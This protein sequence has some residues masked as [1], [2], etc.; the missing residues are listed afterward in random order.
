MARSVEH[1][2]SHRDGGHPM[3]K[4]IR[5]IADLLAPAAAGAALVEAGYVTEIVFSRGSLAR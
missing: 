4:I 3:K 2:T 5:F 1:V